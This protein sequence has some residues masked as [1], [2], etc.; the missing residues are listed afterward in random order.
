VWPVLPLVCGLALVPI[1]LV[2]RRRAFLLIALLAVLAGGVTSCTS[3]S[4][5]SGGATPASGSGITP[6]GSYPVLVT[7]T[8]N[9]VSQSVTLTLTVD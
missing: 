3:S 8:S 9:G 5:V 7:A 1:A 4:I 2:R 6:A